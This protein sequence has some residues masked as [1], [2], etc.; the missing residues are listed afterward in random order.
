VAVREGAKMAELQGPVCHWLMAAETSPG[1][2][3]G[4]PAT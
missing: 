4:A 3:V 1:W 2:Q